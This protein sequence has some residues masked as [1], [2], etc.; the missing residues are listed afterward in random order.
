MFIL[1]EMIGVADRTRPHKPYKQ[2]L[3]KPYPVNQALRHHRSDRLSQNR[4][5]GQV[6]TA[7]G[8]VLARAAFNDALIFW[9]EKGNSTTLPKVQDF[10]RLCELSSGASVPLPCSLGKHG[11]R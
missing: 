8:R 3:G 7:P 10:S 9:E 6:K 11:G 4:S 5:V 1:Y 2:I